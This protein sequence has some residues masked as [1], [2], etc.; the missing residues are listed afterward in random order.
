[1]WRPSSSREAAV[2]IAA[3][4]DALLDHADARL[5]L[6][7]ALRAA[8]RSSDADAEER[9]AIEL[10][11]AKGATLLAERARRGVARAGAPMDAHEVR[12]KPAGPARRR[13][14]P[15][16]ATADAARLDAAVAARDRNA[17]RELFAED[18]QVDDHTTGIVF[19][20]RGAVSSF[21]SLITARNPT[22]RNEPL[23]TLGEALAIC[24]FSVSAS[25]LG[26]GKL[27]VGAYEKE[28]IHLNEVDAEGRRRWGEVFATDHLNEAIVR[29]YERYAECLPEGPARTR[30]TTTAQALAAIVLALGPEAWATALTP[31]AEQIDHR[32]LGT[33]NARGRDAI[34]AHI[35][36]L[37]AVADNVTLQTR[38]ILAVEPGA[39]LFRRIHAGN[40]RLGGGAYERLLLLLLTFATDGR[41]AR[42]EFF[43]DTDEV[44][45]CARFDVLT[46]RTEAGPP[47]P[48][49][50]RIR[51]NAARA[52]WV[53]IDAAIAAGDP[54]AFAPLY[55]EDYQ[56]IDHP[57]GST[58]GRE[59][60]LASVKR[61]LRSRDARLYH[62]PLATLGESL[63]LSRRIVRASG[64]GE[65]R[66]DVGEYES[67]AISLVEVDDRGVC[68][69][70]EVFAVEHL[71][72]AIARM[73]QRYA[74]LL[75][76]GPARERATMTALA[77]TAMLTAS[78]D[79]R[80][81]DVGIVEIQ[82]IDHRT[83]GY[84]AA[85]G[86]EFASRWLDSWDELS[87]DRHIRVDDVLA[88]SPDG[89]LRRSTTFGRLR[90]SGGAFESTGY[91]ISVFGPDGRHT[92]FEV[93]D[94]GHEAEALARF[95]EL[96]GERDAEPVAA[97]P[98]SWR[99]RPN[100][101]SA[102]LA[103]IEAG[104]RARDLDAIDAVLGDSLETIEHPSGAIYGR[105]GQLESSKRMMRLPD[106][107]FRI[108]VL[109]T[110]G[111][112]LALHRRLVCASGA[113]GGNFD[114]GPYE[115][116]HVCIAQADAAGC[117]GRSEVFPSDH[118]ADAII[119]LYE[120]R[121]EQLPAGQARRRTAEMARGVAKFYRGLIDPKHLENPFAATVEM[122]DHRR[123][124]LGTLQG[125]DAVLAAV[126]VFLELVQDATWRVDDVL[127]LTDHAT[128]FRST[129]SGI[130]R[131]GG[132]TFER[133]ILS[134]AVYDADGLVSRW[135]TFDV[136]H[137]AEA[138]ARFDE[139]TVE[140]ATARPSR[141]RVRPNLATVATA[142]FATLFAARDDAAL[143]VLFGESLAVI[144]HPNGA[145]YGRNGH[146][147]S[148]RRLQ[149]ATNPK[150]EFES[151][152][153]L[154]ESLALSRRRITA[155]GSRGRRFDVAEWQREEILL[156]EVDER[157]RIQRLEIFADDRLR[158]AIARLYERYAELIPD[159]AA[160]MRAGATAHAAAALL[161]ALGH[162]D[163]ER[164]V[165][166][167]AP[168]I[169]FTEH[170]VVTLP[171]LRG[172]D[173]LKRAFLAIF[174]VTDDIDNRTEDILGL[175]ANAWLLRATLSG[176]GRTSGGVFE[177]PL[178]SLCVFG[179]DGRAIRYEVFDGDRVNAALERF[180]DLT[181]RAVDVEPVRPSPT[182]RFANAATRLNE[183]IARAW[184]ARD[185]NAVTAVHAPAGIFD[186][187][188]RLLQMRHSGERNLD[189]L[190]FFF[191]V[192]GS[193]WEMSP[194]ATRGERLALSRLLFEGNVDAGGGALA[195]D[196]LV[197]D[198]V[199]AGGLS[200]A[201]VLFD[202]DNL[203]AAFTELDARY[204]AGEAK[205]HERASAFFRRYREVVAAREW[206]SLAAL[207]APGIVAED[208]R[209]VSWGTLRGPASWADA[210]RKLLELAPDT[211]L[212]VDHAR[213]SARAVLFQGAWVGTRDGGEFEIP[214]T[215]VIELDEVGR[216]LRLDAYDDNRLDDALARFEEIAASATMPEPRFANAASRAVDRLTSRFYAHDW[217]GLEAGVDPA[218]RVHDR[219]R[220]MHL[221]S[222]AAEFLAGHKF[223]FDVPG[224]H[225]EMALVATRGER[226][227]LHHVGFSGNIPDGGGRFEA[228]E[229]LCSRR[230]RCRFSH[231]RGRPLRPRRPRRGLRRARRAL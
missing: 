119:R 21:D 216:Q 172:V 117:L 130:D 71:G 10:W 124:G 34:V 129:N 223:M 229:H 81:E 202:A 50:R 146:L 107:D 180:D 66:F 73:Y 44:A 11:E 112:S 182:V 193:R 35:G 135:E 65:G 221:E 61:L 201:V 41:V 64:T 203:D 16:A 225:W 74:E 196:F 213:M 188:R 52:M 105:D 174:E 7:A 56:E 113:S 217:A 24:R 30:A 96:V 87:Q 1:M 165:S 166:A 103:R 18:L 13:V 161:G 5:A 162:P 102:A 131:A 31:D 85:E 3:A 8:G 98:V 32:Q 176:T 155:S 20:R 121:A 228:D 199:D 106:L 177:R 218:A 63:D 95:D 192:P 167:F 22:C 33:W 186:D 226:L 72:D 120:L 224:V 147:D 136:G 88:V 159:G 17:L 99:V 206:G 149:R 207:C 27:D 222:S 126:R 142:R 127:A 108:E 40:E 15:N 204:E 151:L 215:A 208:H 152:A 94:V 214:V 57:T 118:L 209:L 219:R 29:L 227:S 168:D 62:E 173:E 84:G 128:L 150:L 58:Y 43:D 60:S 139:L 115:L 83:V 185:W 160:R 148:V 45:A 154:G 156:S 51:M 49:E 137:E 110:L 97:R 197:V 183:A 75:P 123:V 53:R 78:K 12:V 132:G 69:R 47:R 68:V 23:A 125:A 93:F 46:G 91:V 211:G 184:D 153:T 89:L 158:D 145:A 175:E 179:P 157:A 111:D 6:A 55:S 9:R 195:I 101:A 122:V 171:S 134:L 170:G 92:R 164:F 70:Q 144:D 138:L 198:E 190:R 212:R 86:P 79:A 231:R 14:R 210:L 59:G 4:T 191:D 114:V 178:L 28:E 220:M 187:R 19:D 48:V 133:V 230:A 181:G 200:T 76:E 189:Q 141:R 194:L 116:E 26:R 2:A 104:F 109:A 205:V 169:E 25:G 38:E 77:V 90:A 140:P 37:S 39:V 163:G 143:E 67:E 42:V 54:D 100:A 36:S 80:L 82:S